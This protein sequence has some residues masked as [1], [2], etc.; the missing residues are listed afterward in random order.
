M[1]FER[2]IANR[3]LGR[4]EHNFSRP[5]IRIATITIALGVVVMI[6][7][8][9]ILRGFQREITNKV[10]GFGSHITIRSYG[11]V[12]DYDEMPISL[13]SSESE[14]LRNIPGVSSIQP[15]AYKGGMMKTDEQILGIILKGLSPYSDTSF[16]SSNIIR[17]HLPTLNDSAVSNEI[18]ISKRIAQLMKVDTGNRVATYFWS[19]DNYRA[20]NFLVVGIY[21]TDLNEFDDHYIIGDIR[22]VQRLNRWDS[23]QVAGYELTIE[24][25]DN[26]YPILQEVKGATRPD[27]AVTSI[28]EEQ[29]SM[30]AWLDL[31][32]SNIVLILTIMAIVCAA[33]VASAIL[34]MIFEK[35]Q[36]IGIL[37]TLGCTNRSIRHIFI[38]KALSIIAKALIIGNIIALTFALLQYHFHIISLNPESYSMTFVPIELNPMFFISIDLGTII[39]CFIALLLPSTL[40]SNIHPAR[41]IRVE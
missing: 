14:A 23:S 16:F 40:I 13:S 3:M 30:F 8:V 12:N 31:L 34:I 4:D 41:T 18:A 9:C 36:M 6:M 5:L 19:G 39:I 29:P 21:N 26:L 11:W 27:L 1:S 15:Y 28:R 37:K 2:I 20:R 38:I 33:S 32:N 25:F 35:T 7:A 24:H 22:Q 17:G 10:V